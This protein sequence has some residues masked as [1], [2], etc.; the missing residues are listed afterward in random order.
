VSWNA[1]TTGWPLTD[2]IALI[3]LHRTCS[4]HIPIHMPSA[5]GVQ[6]HEQCLAARHGGSCYH[7][8]EVGPRL[9]QHPGLWDAARIDLKH[10]FP[11]GER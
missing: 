10:N 2:C 6:A 5:P 9:M 7:C 4:A 11:A 1:L 8:I 3:I